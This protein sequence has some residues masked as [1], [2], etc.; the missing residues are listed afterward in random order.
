M[1]SGEF[2]SDTCRLVA[3]ASVYTVCAILSLSSN[4]HSKAQEAKSF[5]EQGAFPL[6]P[7]NLPELTEKEKKVLDAARFVRDSFAG[8]PRS[9]SLSAIR[10]TAIPAKS[11]LT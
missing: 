4:T 9:K 5:G 6:P 11:I 7:L 3:L 8:L 10:I 1:R 2:K